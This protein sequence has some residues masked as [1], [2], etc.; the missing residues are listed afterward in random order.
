M[1]SL[2]PS[3][4]RCDPAQPDSADVAS[5]IAAFAQAC[6]VK[7]IHSIDSNSVP[8]LH[9]DAKY[10]AWPA[11]SAKQK[12]ESS[13]DPLDNVGSALLTRA[14][15]VAPCDHNTTA[16]AWLQSP[17]FSTSGRA[18]FNMS[19][20]AQLHDEAVNTLSIS[21]A[22]YGSAIARRCRSI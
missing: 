22:P 16:R 6:L 8:E 3:P 12:L 21:C 14:G 15:G 11:R 2:A 17:F 7:K 9:N 10:H 13:L 4:Q 19:V 1:A 20:G 5:I 18:V